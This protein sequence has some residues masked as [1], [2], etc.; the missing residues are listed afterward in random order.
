MKIKKQIL[1][2]ALIGAVV[3]NGCGVGRVF[4]EDG[5]AVSQPM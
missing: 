5:G 1:L 2:C 4:D 3:L